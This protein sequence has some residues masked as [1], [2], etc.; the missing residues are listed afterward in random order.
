MRL[1]LF[2]LTVFSP[3]LLCGQSFCE[4]I[5]LENDLEYIRLESRPSNTAVTGFIEGGRVT[6]HYRYGQFGFT[7]RFYGGYGTLK[8]EDAFDDDVSVD[9]T[10]IEGEFW[11]TYLFCRPS[12]TYAPFIGWGVRQHRNK[13]TKPMDLNLETNYIYIP[14]GIRMNTTMRAA[15]GIGAYVKM[16]ILTYT[17]WKYTHPLFSEKSHE[18]EK[19]PAFE[20]KVWST[21]WLSRKWRA[22]IGGSFRYLQLLFP[23]DVT[24]SPEQ[25]KQ[26]NFGFHAGLDYHY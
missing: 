10:E 9:Y 2:L 12:F 22:S 4:C 25:K 18:L 21:Y 13:K 7:D 17:W 5:S 15:V 14:V 23:D 6:H 11:L 20:A 24:F 1:A 26:I 19:T 3:L 16:D 8:G